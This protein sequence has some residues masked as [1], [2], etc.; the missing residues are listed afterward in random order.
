MGVIW[1]GLVVVVVER[2]R[3]YGSWGRN[4]MV[5]MVIPV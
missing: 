4:A 1:A 2:G 3:N 5:M